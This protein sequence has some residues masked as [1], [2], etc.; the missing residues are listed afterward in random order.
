MLVETNFDSIKAHTTMKKVSKASE[1][2]K[3]VSSVFFMPLLLGK[4]SINGLMSGVWSTIINPANIYFLMALNERPTRKSWRKL[5]ASRTRAEP[6]PAVHFEAF[7]EAARLARRVIPK[8]TFEYRLGHWGT[9]IEQIENSGGDARRVATNLNR[10]LAQSRGESEESGLLPSRS[11]FIA[12]KIEHLLGRMADQAV[13]MKEAIDSHALDA[14]SGPRAPTKM[15][16][17][18]VWGA[19]YLSGLEKYWLR[20]PSEIQHEM[21]NRILNK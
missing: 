10:L 19:S 5:R 6:M 4:S 18:Q 15:F 1:I 20:I 12:K 9:V 21:L 2:L 13:V 16:P 17:A 3:I 8:E 7:R 14:Y 11:N